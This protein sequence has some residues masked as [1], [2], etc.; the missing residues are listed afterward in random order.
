MERRLAPRF[1]YGATV[2]G[3]V[4]HVNAGP[5]FTE[6]TSFDMSQ[7]FHDLTLN[8]HADGNMDVFINN[9]LITSAYKD[10]TKSTYYTK[11][12]QQLP[13]SMELLLE[14]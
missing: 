1:T 5:D 13:V 4:T 6:V 10:F 9:V 11:N 8:W 12:D 7:T 14:N 3:Y 2:N